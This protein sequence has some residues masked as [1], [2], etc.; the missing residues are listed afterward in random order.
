MPHSPLLSVG[1]LKTGQTQLYLG[2]FKTGRNCLRVQK[3]KITRGENNPVYSNP[4]FIS[5][6]NFLVLNIGKFV[7]VIMDAT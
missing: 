3:G 1:Q 2:E 6:A 4:H 5:T 7:F